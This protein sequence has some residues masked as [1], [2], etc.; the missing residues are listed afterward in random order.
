MA[1]GT[2]S[3]MR[4][5]GGNWTGTL[6][7]QFQNKLKA[8]DSRGIFF[9][10]SAT[11]VDF[12]KQ[13]RLHQ[14]LQLSLAVSIVPGM[15]ILDWYRKRHSLTSTLWVMSMN[16]P[17]RGYISATTTAY[18]LF[19]LHLTEKTPTQHPP[20]NVSIMLALCAVKFTD[21]F[22][23]QTHDFTLWTLLAQLRPTIVGQATAQVAKPQ[24][25]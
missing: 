18:T 13:I 8:A 5:W 19:L 22:R 20:C 4:T 15:R 12:E 10:L 25:E 23:A 17:V 1:I 7:S 14:P 3:S 24:K 9:A 2:I 21:S 16:Q 6:C 11:P